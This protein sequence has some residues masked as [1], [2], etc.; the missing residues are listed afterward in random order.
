M[1]LGISHFK[2]AVRGLSGESFNKVYV[3][4]KRILHTKAVI[5]GEI[6]NEGHELEDGVCQ[7]CGRSQEELK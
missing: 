6:R 7:I 4:R 1:F 2:Q 3:G 5:L